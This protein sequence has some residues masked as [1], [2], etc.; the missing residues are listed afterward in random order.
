MK[1]YFLSAACIT[2]LLLGTTIAANAQETKDKE[3]T[4]KNKAGSGDEIIIKRKSTGKDA[5]VIVEIKDGE[6]FV[7]G[8][9]IEDFDDDDI[10]VIKRR[11]P[12]VSMA[13]PSS[14]FRT[15]N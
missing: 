9:P 5:K 10:A 6:V 11:V 1:K 7:N 13:A 2:L 14:Q 15:Y 3:K 8:K 12:R 4:E